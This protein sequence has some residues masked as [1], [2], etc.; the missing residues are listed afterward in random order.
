MATTLI[1]GH[2]VHF[3]KMPDMGSIPFAVIGNSKVG[4]RV[5]AW[6]NA[7]NPLVLDLSNYEG[8]RPLCEGEPVDDLTEVYCDGKWVP[9]VA[10]YSKWES[11]R[12]P[13]LPDGK[14][15]L[16]DEAN[17]DLC[18]GGRFYKKV[19]HIAVGDYVWARKHS[20][21]RRVEA[22]HGDAV[23]FHGSNTWFSLTSD[24]VKE[25]MVQ[26][27]E[28]DILRILPARRFR[29][30][31]PIIEICVGS[32]QFFPINEFPKSYL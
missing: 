8:F 1:P 20:T 19:Q 23:M 18:V 29:V 24:L 26:L 27:T 31:G 28:K 17:H 16:A 25:E 14:W 13:I 12:K 11:Y 7:L 9:A 2:P 15:V 5:I 3:E 30:T 32:G 21:L 6:P 22:I 4:F 10:P